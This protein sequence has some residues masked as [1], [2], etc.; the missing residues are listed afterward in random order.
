M[1]EKFIYKKLL[2]SGY[3]LDVIVRH[4]NIVK[5]CGSFK[6]C[7]YASD[8]DVMRAAKECRDKALMDFRQN[9][10]IIHELTVR[11]C[12]DKTLELF[13]TN[14]KTRERHKLIFSQ[15]VP[16]VLAKKPISKV[17]ASEIQTGINKFAETHSPDALSRTLSLWKRIYRAALMSGCP[18]VDQ[19]QLVILP[20][21]KKPSA[22]HR[23]HCTT[24]ELEQFLEGLAD[25]NSFTAEGRKLSRD[26]MLAIR[27][28]QHLGLRPQE[29]FAL[30]D[31][32]IDLSRNIVY[33]RRSVGSNATDKRQ[34]I[35][36][37]TAESVRVLP[38]PKQLKPYIQE[39]MTHDTRP[40]LVDLDGKPYDT[41]KISVLMC[42]VSKRKKVPR[43]NLYMLRHLFGTDMSKQDVKLA[44]TMMGHESARMT[45][46]Y[47]KESSIEDMRKAMEKRYS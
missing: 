33:I 15:L 31:E 11:E 47:A 5:R 45:L 29:A 19:S 38:I 35:A 27:I 1:A 25:Y 10:V 6:R 8:R 9:R 14:V 41:S 3:R 43:I 17:T 21:A 46:G 28:M 2:K 34:L 16:D 13:V 30:C 7:D 37:K 24:A 36:T 39:L 20:K 18:V 4:D 22:P 26:V 32:D 23:K 12:F 44:Q 42:N 40:L